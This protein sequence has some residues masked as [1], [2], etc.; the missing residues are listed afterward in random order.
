MAHLKKITNRGEIKIK[1]NNRN[2]PIH[3]LMTLSIDNKIFSANFG[4]YFSPD[5]EGCQ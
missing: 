4:E 1:I 2:S 3:N 5:G